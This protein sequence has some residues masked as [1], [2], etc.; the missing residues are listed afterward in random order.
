[1]PRQSSAD[2]PAAVD[3]VLDALDSGAEPERRDLAAA[4]RYLARSLAARAPG[5]TVEL[6]VPPHVAVQCV[7]GPRHTRGTPPNVVETTPVTWLLLA[8]G[9][10]AWSTAVRD[11]QVH[12]SGDRADLADY[13]PVTGGA[14]QSS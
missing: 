6:R 8:T 9:R 7:A 4:C 5:R 12:A 13:L 2:G 11:G 10:L 14:G 3:R 1:M